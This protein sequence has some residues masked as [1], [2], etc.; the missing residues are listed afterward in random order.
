MIRGVV[1]F[2]GAGSS[3]DH[4]SL[5]AI[6]SVLSPLAVARVDFLYRRAGKKLPD[7]A[8]VLVRAVRDA[9][10]DACQRWSCAP[11]DV[12]IGGRSMG[13]RMCSLA[14][15]GFDG[16]DRNAQPAAEPLAVAGLVCI[17][18]PLH[19]PKQPMKLRTAHLPHVAAPSLF[20][21]G[22]RDEFASTDELT[23]HLAVMPR[24]PEVHFVD[25]ARH[26]LRGKDDAVA[27]LVAE[28]VRGLRA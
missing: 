26:D 25:G 3:A 5:V 20:V 19:P 2:P 18:Y 9:V 28:W 10:A 7:R 24:A 8:P 4:A 15:A 6:E 14:V 27:R 17:A 21:S 1:M 22:T 11:S 16:D 23:S 12:V 13:G